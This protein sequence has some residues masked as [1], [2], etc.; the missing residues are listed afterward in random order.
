VF[1]SIDAALGNNLPLTRRLLQLLRLTPGREF[2]S[3]KEV[4]SLYD[5]DQWGKLKEKGKMSLDVLESEL[6]HCSS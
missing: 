4:L 6:A 2:D 1:T 3:V 5:R